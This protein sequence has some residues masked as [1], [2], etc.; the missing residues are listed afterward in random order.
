[1]GT[2]KGGARRGMVAGARLAY[3][4]V[5]ASKKRKVG[6]K[7]GKRAGVQGAVRR[8]KA[9]GA[10]AKGGIRLARKVHSVFQ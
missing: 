10:S 3:D 7:V 8:A 6:T 4:N 5:G 9:R 1:M 2:K